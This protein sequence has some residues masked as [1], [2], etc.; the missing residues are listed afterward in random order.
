MEIVLGFV[1]VVGTLFVQRVFIFFYFLLAQVA[2]Q[3]RG[4]SRENYLPNPGFEA[5]SKYWELVPCPNGDIKID[6]TVSHSGKRSICMEYHR[7]VD[8]RLGTIL[9]IY[10]GIP[11]VLKAGQ[12]YTYSGWVKIA[13]V[14]KGKSGPTAYLCESHPDRAET[15]GLT[16]NTD[17]AKNNGWVF[18]S[19]RYKFPKDA[20]YH[21][22]R[23]HV[24]APPDGMAGTVWF[25]DLKVEEGDEPTA[26]RPDWIDPTELYT[27]EPQVP[28]Q[29]VPLDYRSRMDVVT[30]HIELA[31]PYAGATPRVLWAGFSNNARVGCELA[32]RGSLTLDS[33]VLNASSVD[34]ANVRMLHE[35]CVEVF[36]AR[37]GSDPKLPPD[38]RPQVLVIEQGTLELL[39]RQDRAAILDCVAHGMG[40]VVLLGPIRVR[41]HPGAVPTPKIQELISASEKLRPA[42]GYPAGH[43]RV[44]TA[45]NVDQHPLWQRGVYGIE[46]AYGDM[47]LAIYRSIGKTPANVRASPRPPQPVAGMPWAS[48]RLRPRRDCPAKRF[49]RRAGRLQHS[50]GRLRRF[51]TPH[52]RGPD[53]GGGGCRRARHGPLRNAASSARRIHAAGADARRAE[54]G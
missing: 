14:P 50:H 43:G 20:N 27:R 44:I 19:C 22:F 13:G 54:K 40:C 17:P 35:K 30:P 37:L 8:P 47:L 42:S 6:D 51:A 21:Q 52:A 28:Y 36:R 1:F 10:Q 45:M 49:R 38:K 16:G 15:T 34:S 2:A 53:G 41:D 5:G 39:N 33:V 7:E 12:V 18:V 32:Q 4:Q 31:R 24:Q 29:V 26:F 46:A 9:Y 11:A 48:R 23:C 25:D 3:A